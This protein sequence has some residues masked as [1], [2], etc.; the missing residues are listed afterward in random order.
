MD[1]C[2]VGGRNVLK[3]INKVVDVNCSRK[4]SELETSYEYLDEEQFDVHVRHE[5]VD[6]CKL[7]DGT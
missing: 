4:R 6:G 1:M 3:E 7:E 2:E 5:V